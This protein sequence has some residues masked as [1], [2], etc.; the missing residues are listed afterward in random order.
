MNLNI[1]DVSETALLTLY[2]HAFDA[3]TK[4]PILNDKSSVKS[5]QLLNEELTK[6]D[7]KLHQRL[8]K[9]KIDRNGVIHIAIRAKRY[10]KYISDFIKKYPKA[11]IVNIGCGLDN[12][13]ERIDNGEIEFFD[14]DLPDI[15][16]IKKQLFNETN[17]FHFISQS[18]F[19]FSWIEN[20]VSIAKEEILFIAEGV[21]MYCREEDVK[22]LFLILQEKFPG[23]EMVCEVFNSM[24]LKG[25]LKKLMNFK[26]QKELHLGKDATFHFGIRDSNE[27]ESWN[28]G[29]NLI[30]DWS[31]FDSDEKKLGWLKIFRHIKLFR[32]TQWS[33][34]YKLN[35]YPK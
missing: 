24:W 10:D 18:V 9:G 2:S 14:L 22:S 5:V 6:S 32:K 7:K 34:H 15:I 12:R 11:K 35:K 4:E 33:V 21:F 8:S 29:I 30:D 3:Q 20:I 1:N 26:M 13:F 31:Y 28:E 17:R 23:S 16:E 27:M 19:D 25:W